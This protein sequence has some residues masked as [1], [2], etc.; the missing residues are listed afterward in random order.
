MV[1][2]G[3]VQ[4][5]I[6]SITV[7]VPHFMVFDYYDISFILQYFWMPFGSTLNRTRFFLY[8]LQIMLR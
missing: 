2:R 6:L 3:H 5:S 1:G 7:E 4:N 8:G